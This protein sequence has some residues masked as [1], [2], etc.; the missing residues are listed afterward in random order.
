[1]R[2]N[3]FKNLNAICVHCLWWNYHD[4]ILNLLPF[5]FL[6]DFLLYQYY[7]LHHKFLHN[8]ILSLWSLS[9]IKEQFQH[10]KKIIQYQVK[11]QNSLIELWPTDGNDHFS[12][13]HCMYYI[14]WSQSLLALTFILNIS[15]LTF[16]LIIKRHTYNLAI[17][18]LDSSPYSARSYFS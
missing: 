17:Q 18:I 1:M 15:F 16:Y 10:D 6:N 7:L 3:W 12:N 2:C 13:P 9:R 11:P 8:I 4:V 5:S 14:I